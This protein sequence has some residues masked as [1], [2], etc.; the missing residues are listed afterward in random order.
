MST[1]GLTQIEHD[2]ETYLIDRFDAGF[3]MVARKPEVPISKILP[4]LVSRH[5]KIAL[6]TVCS[7]VVAVAVGFILGY[8]VGIPLAVFAALMLTIF[9]LISIRPW[10]RIRAGG[11]SIEDWIQLM[12]RYGGRFTARGLFC[13]PRDDAHPELSA[14]ERTALDEANLQGGVRG[15][16]VQ[17]MMRYIEERGSYDYQRI[18]ECPFEEWVASCFDMTHLLEDGSLIG[19]RFLPDGVFVTRGVDALF[20]KSIHTERSDEELHSLVPT[21]LSLKKD[22]EARAKFERLYNDAIVAGASRDYPEMAQIREDQ[23]TVGERVRAGRESVRERLEALR[24]AREQRE[25]GE[26]EQR[27]VSR[28]EDAL[29]SLQE[30]RDEYFES[31]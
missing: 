27:K 29:R 5:W 10:K 21:M 2:G 12:E 20:I 14:D 13:D 18:P 17:E 28:R 24:V 8:S 3:T 4:I 23:A 31:D 19:G 30:A 9:V 11:R 25:L 7:A 22:V 15:R 6:V 1:E 26:R 16:Y